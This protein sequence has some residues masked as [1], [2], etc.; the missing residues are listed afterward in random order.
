MQ[1]GDELVERH[2]DD[3]PLAQLE[4]GFMLVDR[5][6]DRRRIVLDLHGRIGGRQILD[7]P[8]QPIQVGLGHHLVP[9]AVVFVPG[10]FIQVGTPLFQLLL[11]GG[12]QR[13]KLIPLEMPGGGR[14]TDRGDLLLQLVYVLLERRGRLLRLDRGLRHRR[15][16]RG[17][18]HDQ[19]LRVLT[20]D[21][22]QDDQ[23]ANDI[24]HDVQKR[25]V[26][27]RFDLGRLAS[28]HGNLSKSLKSEVR[29]VQPSAFSLKP[30][31]A[32]DFP[33]WR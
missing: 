32:A 17:L 26:T 14:L 25:F 12:Q 4:M 9:V 20:D 7:L 1:L 19:R 16:S 18:G 10:V 8:L 21:H 31:S 5:A 2:V 6:A 3:P 11:G 33:D 24:G 29:S 15:R 27:S 22:H 23:N 13:R 28:T 30:T